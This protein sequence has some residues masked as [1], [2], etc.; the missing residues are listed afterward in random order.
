MPR[1]IRLDAPDTLHHVMVRGIESIVCEEEPY[2]RELVRYIH[3]NPLRAGQVG[4]M[5]QLSSLSYGRKGPEWLKTELILGYF[6]G[7]DPRR[8]YRKKV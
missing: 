4:S 2:F 6:S 5:E 3:L 8:A 7:E 1:G